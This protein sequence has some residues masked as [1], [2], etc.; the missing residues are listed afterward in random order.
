MNLKH[1]KTLLV[2]VTEAVLEK[3]L[4][5][6]AKAGGAQGWTVSD[7]RG[8]GRSGVREGDWEADRSIEL[9]IICDA[10]VADRIAE[11]VLVT[12]APHYGLS[13][14]FSEVSVLRPDRY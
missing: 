2:I 12:Y 8:G 10:E 6:D 1:T 9:R 11:H 7:V 3:A 14:T 5:R 4:V 13:M